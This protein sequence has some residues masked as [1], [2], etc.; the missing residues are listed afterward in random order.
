MHPDGMKE[1]AKELLDRAASIMEK[2]QKEYSTPQ[3]CMAN[4]DAVA[5]DTG[6]PPM[7]VIF[8]YMSK[9]V[10]A[11]GELS[12]HLADGGDYHVWKERQTEPLI[13]RLADVI[14]YCIFA[15]V[16]EQRIAKG[17]E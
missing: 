17:R 9:P 13:D 8:T 7:Q 1:I 11:V 3:N 14:N 16:E 2:K 10:R 12:R 5:K 4:F 15:A 6:E